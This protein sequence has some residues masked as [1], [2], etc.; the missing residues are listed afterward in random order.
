[1]KKI[2]PRCQSCQERHPES[3]MCP[4]HE[5]RTTGVEWFRQEIAA[6]D[7][8]IQMLET[9]VKKLE[10]QLQELFVSESVAKGVLVPPVIVKFDNQKDLDDA[11]KDPGKCIT[12]RKRQIAVNLAKYL[13]KDQIEIE[14][15]Y[16]KLE[17]KIRHCAYSASPKATIAF[18]DLYSIGYLTIG[19]RRI[20]DEIEIDF[21]QIADQVIS[22]LRS[23]LRK[24][25]EREIIS[26]MVNHKMDKIEN[27]NDF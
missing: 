25:I 24:I 18:P 22:H 9:E 13:G 8:T 14:V 17:M 10:K 1:M 5:C 6:Q 16:P 23:Q 7:E 15:I 27:Q 19:E 3:V 20:T 11:M 12:N 21:D 4:P 2:Y 26:E